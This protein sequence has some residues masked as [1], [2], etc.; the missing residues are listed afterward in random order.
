MRTKV[1]SIMLAAILMVGSAHGQGLPAAS[2]SHAAP[3]A[4]IIQ[5]LTP[6]QL[7]QL[8]APIALYPDDL[9]SDILMAATYPLEVVEAD[10]WVRDPQNAS[11]SGSQLLA[12][13]AKQDWDPS[14]K[15][16]V[17]FSRILRVM[18]DEL[19][20][21]ERLGEA[22]LADQTAVMDSVQRLR[23][24]ALNAQRLASFPEATVT[25]DE[26]IVSI[27]PSTPSLVYI[28]V[29]DPTVVYGD[30]PYPAFPPDTFPVVSDDA[31]VIGLGYRWLS[32]PII[33]PLWGWHHFQWR[34]HNINIDRDRFAVL[35]VG[36]PL[37]EGDTWGHDPSHRGTVAYRGSG[38]RDPFGGANPSPGAPPSVPKFPAFQSQRGPESPLLGSA[39]GSESATEIVPAFRRR[40][41]PVLEPFSNG[42]DLHRFPTALVPLVHA[43]PPFGPTQTVE[44]ATERIEPT[45]RTRVPLATE[46]FARGMDVRI[47]TPR[48]ISR[49]TFAPVMDPRAAP[50]GRSPFPGREAGKQ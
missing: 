15:S 12:A 14:V 35:N 38:L 18:D 1:A 45:A 27:E 40:A 20:W 11:L 22:F 8:L 29:Y 9:L 17:P 31:T 13:L 16:L 34:G 47:Q 39:L 26:Q 44:P 30:W 4:Q 28:P 7:D 24:R 49:R 2:Q 32:A 50:G 48:G 10:R 41:V 6:E 33:A 19:D 42:S 43:A 25:T 23:Q 5:Q 46:P 3:D 37:I 21:T 36:H